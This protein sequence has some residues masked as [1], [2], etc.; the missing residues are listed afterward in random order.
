MWRSPTLPLPKAR[1]ST[2][3]APRPSP[4][5]TGRSTTRSG[6]YPHAL[7]YALKANSTLA[8]ARLLRGL[9][10]GAD[11]N[12]GGE[13]DVALRAGFIPE[14][15]V[16]TGVGKTAAE[17]DAGDRPRRQDDQRRVRR[18][19]R[20]HRPPGPR[21]ADARARRAAREPRH[22]RPQPPAHFDRD[23]G[24]QVRHRA[25]RRAR[26]LPPRGPARRTG[27]RR[28]A[29]PRRLADHE[30][31]PA[32]RAPR[33]RSSRSRASSATT[34]SPSITSTSAAASACRTTA[35]RCR[36]PK[37]TPRRCCPR[38]EIRAC[39]SCSNRAATSSRPPARCCRG[40][41][42]SR[43]G[44][45]ARL[46]VILDAGMTELMRPML[47]GAFHRIEPA[48]ATSARRSSATSSDRSARAA[49]RSARIAGCRGRPSA[50][51][52]RCSTP[53]PTAPSWRRTTTA[54][55]CRPKCSSTAA[56]WSVIRR[57]QTID[58]LLA[59]ES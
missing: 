43:T 34:G 10:S 30:P 2:S 13:I 51:S 5:V 27:D 19:A 23:E 35:R 21:A 29:H 47:Y 44:P 31:R 25:G 55:R 1:R 42:T 28:P 26:H 40:S 6:S 11:A 38:S 33:R 39:R 57:R 18:G 45:T 22:R 48:L 15:I 49:T 7:H 46:F 54:G 9:G 8:V 37:T 4:P 20:A 50:T 53:A 16:F 59:L 58:D 41:S 32:P 24:Q 17:L 56:Q 36:A 52:W 12:S 14:Q 3:T